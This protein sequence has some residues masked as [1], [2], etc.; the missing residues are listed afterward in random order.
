MANTRE[1]VKLVKCSPKR[2][3]ILG[4]IKENVEK[5]GASEAAGLIKLS[6]TRWKVEAAGFLHTIDNYRVP[7]RG[8]V[9]RIK[10]T[11]KTRQKGAHDGLT[12]F[13]VHRNLVPP[14]TILSMTCQFM[15]P[16]Q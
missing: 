8:G 7:F 1:I 12:S 9:A 16:Q 11:G 15:V 4:E 13:S 6:I 5:E 2:D 10:G 3:K 14:F